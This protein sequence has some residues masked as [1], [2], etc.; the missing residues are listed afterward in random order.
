MTNN[1]FG[2]N[3]VYFTQKLGEIVR[4]IN[5]YTPIEMSRALRRLS[6]VANPN[7]EVLFV[8]SDSSGGLLNIRSTLEKAAVL[9]HD[10]IDSFDHHGNLVK[11]YKYVESGEYTTEF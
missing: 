2:L 6:D 7:K 10:Y 11:S 9:E 5:H 3:A 8:T 1:V 4:D